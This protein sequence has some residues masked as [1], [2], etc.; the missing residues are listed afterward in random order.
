MVATDRERPLLAE[1]MGELESLEDYKA[2]CS[3]CDRKRYIIERDGEVARAKPC[4]ACFETCPAC[5]GEEYTFELDDQGYRYAVKCQVCGAL[6]ERIEA[7][8]RAKIPAKYHTRD[9]TIE[10]FQTTDEHGSQVGNLKMVKMT[11]FRWV[12]GFTPGDEGFLLHGKVGTGKTHL[13]AAIIRHLTLEKGIRCR[14]I[15]FTHLLS[16][17]KQ[18]YDE[19]RGETQV[20]NPLSNVPV[21]AIDELGKGRNNDWQLSVIDEIISKRYNRG[22]TTLFTTNYPL[23]V[24]PGESDDFAASATQETLRER[25]DERIYSRLHEMARFLEIDAPDFRKRS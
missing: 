7:F 8:N 25:I 20:L 12:R 9:S 4:E 10:M 23:D 6:N 16:E 22:L 14:F 1:S 11:L 3:R 5:G 15:E 21:L 18:G 19:G 2:S 24:S 13:L 17:I